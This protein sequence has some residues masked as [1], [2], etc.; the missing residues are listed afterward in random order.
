MTIKN[1]LLLK[2]A[3]KREYSSKIFYWEGQERKAKKY[4]KKYK[5]IREDLEKEIKHL[6]RKI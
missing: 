4:L 1:N 6:E 5:L 2:V 3:L